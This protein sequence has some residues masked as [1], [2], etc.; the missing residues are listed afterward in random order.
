MVGCHCGYFRIKIFI[1]PPGIHT[2]VFAT[3][4]YFM[5]LPEQMRRRGPRWVGWLAMT[6]S[7]FAV[8]TTNLACSIGFNEAAWV[9]ER[10]YPGGPAA[11]L[12]E[13]QGRA[14][15]TVGNSATILASFLADGLLLNRVYILWNQ[16]WQV[17]VLPSVFYF[18]TIILAI[19]RVVQIPL[20]DFGGMINLGII[21]WS[22]LMALNVY[23]S[24][25]IALRIITM[26]RTVINLLGPEHAGMYTGAAAFVIESAMPFMIVSIILLALFGGNN[27]SQNLFVPLLVQIECIAPLLIILRIFRNQAW[28]RNTTSNHASQSHE[29]GK[30]PIPL[31]PMRYTQTV[32]S[33]TSMTVSE[34]EYAQPRQE[35]NKSTAMWSPP[36]TGRSQETRSTL[37]IV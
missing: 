10:N 3:V 19:L 9:N 37:E 35:E 31:K 27:T 20:K 5:F 34:M 29:T 33:G 18:V 22:S 4:L 30:K 24:A 14:I 11:F 2:A 23:L 28:S 7:L 16:R 25:M 17:V 8:G 6:C 12:T 21:T 15:M 13:Q 1:T 36:Y 26:R 32:S